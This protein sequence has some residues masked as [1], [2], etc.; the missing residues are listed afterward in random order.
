[1]SSSNN[2]GKPKR[3]FHCDKFKSIIGGNSNRNIV[4]GKNSNG[5]I[6]DDFLYNMHDLEELAAL[7]FRD[8]EEDNHQW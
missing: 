5:N 6:E 2:T 7:K 1:M 4:V 8:G 3:Y